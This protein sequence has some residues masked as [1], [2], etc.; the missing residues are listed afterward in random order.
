[1]RV[2]RFIFS[3][4]CATVIVVGLVFLLAEVNDA[5]APN[6][7]PVLFRYLV[8]LAAWPF[9]ITSIILHHD[10]PAGVCWWVLT[11][12][13]GLFWGFIIEFIFV[14]KKVRDNFKSGSNQQ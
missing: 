8:L 10:P 13:A 3:S 7:P 6:L 14:L 5:Y 2:G 9:A 12:V 11:L 1:M 4:F